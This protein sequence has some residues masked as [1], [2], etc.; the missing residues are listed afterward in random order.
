MG[1]TAAS[2]YVVGESISRSGEVGGAATI[3]GQMGYPCKVLVKNVHEETLYC[4]IIS[5]LVLKK[6][7]VE[8]SDVY[9]DILQWPAAAN[10]NF[11]FP[12]MLQN[13]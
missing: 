7:D 3:M 1:G 11:S 2:I 12:E 5:N 6:Q 9:H 10:L 8:S 13:F 4:G